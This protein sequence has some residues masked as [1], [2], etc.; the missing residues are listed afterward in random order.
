[1]D[2]FHRI[3]EE[4]R[5]NIHT[6]LETLSICYLGSSSVDKIKKFDLK[7]QF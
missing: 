7:S 2:T 6:Y 1:M 3:D 5:N 4:F